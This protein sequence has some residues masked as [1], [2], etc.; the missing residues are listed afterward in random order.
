MNYI[1]NFARKIQFLVGANGSGKT[2][3]LHQALKEVENSGILITE[4]GNPIIPRHLNRVNVDLIKMTY[5]YKSETSRG[6]IDR[7]V[8]QEPISER[9]RPIVT[10]CNELKK[11]L[12]I[13][14]KK[15]K[16]QEKLYNIISI[17][18]SY[19]LNNIRIIYFDEPENFLDEEYLKVICKLF[20]I[21]VSQDFIVRVATHNSR[22]LDIIKVEIDDI[23]FLNSHSQFI[24][25]KSEIEDL[26]RTVASEIENIKAKFRIQTDA[27]IEYKLNLPN[28]PEAFNNFLEQTLKSEEF[29][30][31]L[32]YKHVII[33]EGDSDIVALQSIKNEFDSSVEFFNPNGKAYI[34]FFAQLFLKLRKE[35]TVIID[36]DENYEEGRPLSH[37]IA[38]TYYLEDCASRNEI[39]LVKHTPDLERFYNIDL[40]Q[41]GENLG[42]SL[43]VRRNRGY[44]KSVA[45][46][47]F[48]KDKENRE[49]LKR[50]VLSGGK[51]NQFEFE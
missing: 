5:I 9:V 10:F 48:F 2:Y 28:Q 4:D 41:I 27:S 31:C 23:I 47:V 38:I 21:L 50:H 34:P 14:K 43:N 11:K 18:S 1:N 35:V 51:V 33:V 6:K 40:E 13:F 26:Y 42:M 7:D 29:Y 24:T 16:G 8:E 3:S 30:R 49:K 17:L 32:F 12:D 45:A 22:L 19:N 36:G 44:L 20:T 46:F 39:N 37:P 15:S 25:S